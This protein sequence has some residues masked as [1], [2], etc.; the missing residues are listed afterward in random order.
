M[1]IGRSSLPRRTYIQRP[2]RSN[3]P[4]TSRRLLGGRL[5]FE[6]DCG[7]SKPASP[8]PP[9]HTTTIMGC[10]WC[11]WC[12][13]ADVRTPSEDVNGRW[14]TMRGARAHGTNAAD[15]RRFC[16]CP[17]RTVDRNLEKRGDGHQHATLHSTPP[18]SPPPPCAQASVRSH[19]EPPRRLTRPGGAGSKYRNIQVSRSANR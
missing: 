2:S 8:T 11:R 15:P 19:E 18:P 4:H 13:W 6:P 9:R 3:P 10:R 14:M 16:A 12:R 7:P 1:N 17:I 5:I